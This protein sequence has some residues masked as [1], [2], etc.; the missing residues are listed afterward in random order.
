MMPATDTL[1]T[2]A[3]G[4]TVTLSVVPKDQDG[5]TISGL[6][7]PSFSSSNS[8]VASVGDDGTI[9]AQAAGTAV[10]TA[11]L[12]ADGATATGSTTVT[13]QVAPGSALVL[14]PQLAYQPT[15]VDVSAGGTVNW[16]FGPIHHTVTFTTAGAPDDVPELRDGSASRVFPNNGSFNYR[17]DF[18]PAMA[19]IVRVH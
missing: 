15:T 6:A 11:S 14:A 17:C 5:Q 16:T 18:H 1:F 9:T 7:S 4:N 13:V 10:I 8:A 2:V 19:G 3:P 12:T